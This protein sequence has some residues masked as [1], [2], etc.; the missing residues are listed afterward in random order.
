VIRAR[1]AVLAAGQPAT[2]GA[3]VRANFGGVL[4]VGGTPVPDADMRV[5]P[6]AAVPVKDLDLLFT[7]ALEA[8][9][10]AILNA[11]FLAETTTGDQGHVSEAVPLD[12]VSGRPGSRSTSGS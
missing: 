3:I 1:R 5:A 10:E 11:L 12:L 6:E 8:T 7:A 9:E 4:A 2:V